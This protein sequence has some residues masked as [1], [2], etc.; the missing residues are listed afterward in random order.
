MLPSHHK[1]NDDIIKNMKV[2]FFNYVSVPYYNST[3][4]YSVQICL[5]FKR[6]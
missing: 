5:E 3:I 6:I 2:N 4:D 1:L